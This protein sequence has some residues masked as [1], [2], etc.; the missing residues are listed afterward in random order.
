MV[1]DKALWKHNPVDIVTLYSMGD[2]HQV[3]DVRSHAMS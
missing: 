3:S 1:L 2:Y